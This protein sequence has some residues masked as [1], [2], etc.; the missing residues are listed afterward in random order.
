MNEQSNTNKNAWEYLA[1]EFWI[2]RDGFPIQI[3]KEM[4]RKN[5]PC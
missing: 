1:Y 5:G 2:K 4:M 3:T